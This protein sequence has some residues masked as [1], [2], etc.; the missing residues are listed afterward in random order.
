MR[1][2][3]PMIEIR[4]F[5]DELAA[6]F[7]C[8]L[9]AMIAW[10]VEQDRLAGRVAVS[11]GP[12]SPEDVALPPVVAPPADVD[13]IIGIRKFREEFAAEHDYDIPAIFATLRR[14]G[15]EQG[16]ETGSPEL[17]KLEPDAPLSSLPAFP[18]GGVTPIL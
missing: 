13:P 1:D 10:V 16:H 9:P 15:E 6:R 12:P 5:R 11:P 7:D 8:N 18:A 2:V 17:Q 3:D 14:I 4:K